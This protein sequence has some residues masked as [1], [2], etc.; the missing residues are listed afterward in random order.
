MVKILLTRIGPLLALSLLLGGCGHLF[1]WP[2]QG[3]RGTPDQLGLAYEPV[4]LASDRGLRLHGWFFPVREDSDVPYRG[5][6]YFLHGN[7]ENIS[8]HFSALN[9]VTRHGWSFFILDYRGYGL[10]EGSP[11]IQ[12]VH[13]D[14]LV[15]LRWSL[16]RAQADQVPLVVLGQS[17]GA[18]TAA[19]LLALAPEAGQVDAL[20]LDSAFSGYRRM[21]REKMSE[22][23]LLWAFQYP[24]SWLVTDRYSP[25]QQLHKLPAD[26]PVLLLHGCA[27]RITPC[28]HSQRLA[29]LIPE[30]SSLWLDEQ[31]QHIQMLAQLN[32]RLALLEWL[33]QTL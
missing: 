21:A 3:L 30:Q 9:W 17:I 25:E 11:D 29:A 27:D 31:A 28:S 19:T 15:G 7:A 1:Y 4:D 2:E 22:S 14:A 18:T 23:W 20:V 5:M 10:S 24:L 16:Q 33:N 13:H 12:G 32:W 8:T 6:I 26:L